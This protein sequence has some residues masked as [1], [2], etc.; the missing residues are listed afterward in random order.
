MKCNNNLSKVKER[1]FVT[2]WCY[3][4]KILLSRCPGPS[5][6][7]ENCHKDKED[8]LSLGQIW[9]K[10]YQENILAEFVLSPSVYTKHSR[11]SIIFV[12][13]GWT[14]E[15]NGCEVLKFSKGKIGQYHLKNDESEVTGLFSAFS[16]LRLPGIGSKHYS[17]ASEE[18]K[19]THIESNGLDIPIRHLFKYQMYLL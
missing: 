14:S 3:P 8:L 11:N 9:D 10:R 1:P 7:P 16:H 19:F 12:F 2:R 18:P 5:W 15:R 6:C 13:F 4:W 17:P